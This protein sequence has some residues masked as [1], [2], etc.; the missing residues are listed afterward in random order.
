MAE[1]TP[2]VVVVEK[3]RGWG[4]WGCGCGVLLAIAVLVIAL[5]VF[6]GRSF[7]SMAKTVTS[8]QGTTIQTTD[9]GDAVYTSAQQK[10]TAFQQAV[11]QHQ[12]GSLH[13]TSDEINTL[14]ARDP[15]YAKLH[16]RMHISLAADAAE[17]ESSLQLGL[18]EKAFMPE[19]YFNS[20]ATLGVGFIPATHALVVDLRRLQL[21][22]Q[23]MPANANASLNQSLSTFLNQQLQLNP[24]AKTFLDRAQKVAI[25]NGQLVIETR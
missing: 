22:G 16:G 18:V 20:D 15:N 17:I 6:M 25:E 3:K 14:I 5:G 7:Y 10:V 13:L 8:E 1:T 2:P 19:R 4:C 11:E 24:Q 23:T 9:G 12:P 21:N